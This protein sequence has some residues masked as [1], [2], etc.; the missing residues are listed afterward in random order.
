MCPRPAGSRCSASCRDGGRHPV[1]TT[2]QPNLELIIHREVPLLDERS[3]LV[4]EVDADLRAS[5]E[6][7]PE[8]LSSRTYSGKFNLR[9]GERLHRKL[10][11]EAAE[12]R[13]SLSQ[14]V[15]RRVSDAS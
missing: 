8:S 1:S 9:V 10:A 14:Y 7:V 3:D 15:V 6:A 5:S 12:E 4:T 13:L 11:M 2:A